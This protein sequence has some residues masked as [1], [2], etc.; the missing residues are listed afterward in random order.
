MNL[1]TIEE[2]NEKYASY[3]LKNLERFSKDIISELKSLSNNI[4]SEDLTLYEDHT[5]K[6]IITIDGDRTLD[7]DDAIFVEKLNNLF[8]LTVYIADVSHYVKEGSKLDEEALKR[9]TSIYLPHSTLTMLPAKLCHDICSLKE[10]KKRLT[11]AINMQYDKTGKLKNRRIFKA[12]I[13]SKK[14]MTYTKVDKLLMSHD[15]DV[16]TEYNDFKEQLFLMKD[17]ALI[18]RKRRKKN[19]FLELNIP[20]FD[21]YIPSSFEFEDMSISLHKSTISTTIIEEFMLAANFN[22]AEIFNNLCVPFV[23]RTHGMPDLNNINFE[24]FLNPKKILKDKNCLV[25]VLSKKLNKSLGTKKILVSFNILNSLTSAKYSEN[26]TGHFALNTNL[27]C[28]FT[29][30]IRRYPDLFIHRIISQYIEK[31]YVD[32]EMIKKYQNLAPIVAQ[33][34]SEAE[35]FAKRT[36]RDFENMYIAYYMQEFMGKNFK[37]YIYKI[38]KNNI[39]VFIDNIMV[40]GK[41]KI[42]SITDKT[43]TQPIFYKNQIIFDEQNIFSLYDKLTVTLV[44]I[45]KSTNTLMFEII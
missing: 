9:G 19:H 12:I 25:R 15:N 27:Y 36:S 43:H 22:I 45:D 29:S 44:D 34:C 32:N 41:I 16:I 30:P 39:S 37:G 21:F 26:P 23:F 20:E 35:S 5:D 13:S 4:E 38:S 6:N 17:L 2:I 8:S 1:Y 31:G 10:N 28:H 24:L 3:G 7:I 40:T 33:K 18:L 11:L 42:S 14:K